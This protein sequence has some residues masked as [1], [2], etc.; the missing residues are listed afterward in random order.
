MLIQSQS[1]SVDEYYTTHTIKESVANFMTLFRS[2]L[3]E[4][5][6]TSDSIIRIMI[7][8]YP[9]FLGAIILKRRK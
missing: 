9:I 4:L 1:L 2:T 5:Y 3:P 6:V 7:R 8:I